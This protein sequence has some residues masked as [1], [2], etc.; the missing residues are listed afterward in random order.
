MESYKNKSLIIKSHIKTLFDTE[1][2][3]KASS[4]SLRNLIELFNLILKI[5]K[6]LDLSTEKLDVLLIHLIIF[7]L[8]FECLENGRNLIKKIFRSDNPCKNL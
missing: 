2:V 3:T 8:D 4:T 1:P 5:L 6:K 7:K